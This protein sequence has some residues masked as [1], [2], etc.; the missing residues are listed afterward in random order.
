MIVSA[1][2]VSLQQYTP[3]WESDSTRK[4]Y[5][6]FP[7]FSGGRRRSGYSRGA[8]VSYRCFIDRLPALVDEI[9]GL[10]HCMF[11]NLH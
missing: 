2:C 10:F 6:C 3:T 8:D 1:S 11:V 4:D 9:W 5:Y 7:T